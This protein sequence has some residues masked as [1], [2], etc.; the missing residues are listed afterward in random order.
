MRLFIQG[1]KN[2]LNCTLIVVLH[3]VR[4]GAYL[5]NVVPCNPLPL[6]GGWGMKLISVS[7]LRRRNMKRK[8]GT[9]KKRNKEER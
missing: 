6:P 5:E 7:V 2:W 1:P 4:Q 9:K 8:R 3:T